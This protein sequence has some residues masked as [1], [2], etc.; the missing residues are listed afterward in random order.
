MPNKPKA[1]GS[2][3]SPRVDANAPHGR[4]ARANLL[5]AAYLGLGVGRTLD[6]AR[7]IV[8]AAG[9]RMAR[10][11]AN[12]YSSDFHFV[13][14]AA[15]FDKSRTQ[16][17]QAVVLDQAIASDIQHAQLGRSLQQLAVTAIAWRLQQAAGGRDPQ[18]PPGDI[19]RLADI[20][21]KI[22]RLASGQATEIR[23]VMVEFYGVLIRD[24]GNLWTDSVNALLDRLQLAGAE[25]E[26]AFITAAAVFGPGADRALAQHLHAV[27]FQEIEILASGRNE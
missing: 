19:A 27:G 10:T 3:A 12:S 20:G 5:L 17:V 23:H 11:T 22:E 9:V 16:A 8:A 14:R 25:R 1:D 7:E 2:P 13:E 18:V 6:R 24:L 26:E 4:E 21:V 15:E